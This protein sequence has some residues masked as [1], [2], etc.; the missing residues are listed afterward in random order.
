MISHTNSDNRFNKLLKGEEHIHIRE[1]C[2]S[3]LYRE[4]C[5]KT[6]LI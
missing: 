6:L 5:P 1:V 3:V 4:G 2:A